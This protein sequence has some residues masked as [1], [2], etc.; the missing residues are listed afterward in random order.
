VQAARSPRPSLRRARE[1]LGVAAHADAAQ[2]ARAYRRQAR[3]LHPDISVEPDATER[4]WMLQAAYQVALAAAPSDV[5]RPA[6]RVEHQD[7]TV[8]LADPAAVDR[9]ATAGPGRGV[10]WL[11]AGP[12]HVEPL[13][14]RDR[15]TTALSSEEGP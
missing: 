12:V 9:P 7:P 14:D 1:L 8:V 5:P 6:A 3:L 11:A 10:A 4:F 2:L 13:R 15:D